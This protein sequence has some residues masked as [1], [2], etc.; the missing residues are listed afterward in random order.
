LG[1]VANFNTKLKS[2]RMRKER[3]RINN[4]RK[5][6]KVLYVARNMRKYE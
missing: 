2:E 1:H 5:N 4:E 6:E 3:E